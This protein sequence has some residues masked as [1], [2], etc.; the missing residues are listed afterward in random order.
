MKSVE[1]VEAKINKKGKVSIVVDDAAVVA[2]KDNI[3]F[4]MLRRQGLG[5]SDSSVLLGVNLYTKLDELIT[6]KGST[7]ITEDELKVSNLVQVRKGR[8]LEPIILKK[9]EEF[10]GI[11]VDKPRPMYRLIECEALTINY[12]GVSEIG[13]ALIPIEAKYVSSYAGKY[14]DKLRRIHSV[15][16]LAKSKTNSIRVKYHRDIAEH[17]KLVSADYGIPPYYYTQIQQQ[18]LGLDA[19]FGILAALFDKD[20][21]LN[22]FAI[23]RDYVVQEQLKLKAE[24]VW[25][26]IKGRA[27]L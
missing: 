1:L 26:I 7:V 14:W 24:H 22:M 27:E 3:A 18:L 5:A 16:D 25:N 10:L 6:Q 4:A 20:W 23:P 13:D 15:L 17:I 21:E 12:D 19:P 9:A 11:P 2:K 8:D